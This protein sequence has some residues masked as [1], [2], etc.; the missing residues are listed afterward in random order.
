M[1][2]GRLP[3]DVRLLLL[4]SIP[5]DEESLRFLGFEAHIDHPSCPGHQY[6]EGYFHAIH[7][8]GHDFVESIHPRFGCAIRR[9]PAPAALFGFCEAFRKANA[10]IFD[11]LKQE[12]AN[13]P[14]SA[15]FAS[16]L[17]SGKHFADISVQ[18]H[19]GD[20][21]EVGDVAWH[22]DAPN[23]FL[24]MALGLSGSRALHARRDVRNGRVSRNCLIGASDDREIIWQSE[25]EVYLGAP[26][27]YPHAVEYPACSWENRI[28]AVQLRLLLME[29]ELFGALDTDSGGGTA[30]TFFRHLD[31]QS[32]LVMPSVSQLRLD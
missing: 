17:D 12:L 26:C 29:E 9:R 3:E 1:V 23:S 30:K 7:D 32:E 8:S 28:I 5:Q 24:H 19:W 13:N 2:R 31:L 21:V 18:I 16:V 10:R 20:A 25:G 4:S 22:I 15:M 27:C 11:Q 14:N 6:M